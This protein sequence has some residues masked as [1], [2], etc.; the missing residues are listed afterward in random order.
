MIVGE[1]LKQRYVKLN[2]DGSAKGQSG[3][4]AAGGLIKDE[5]GNWIVGFTFKIGGRVVSSRPKGTMEGER[6]A[7]VSHDLAK[8]LFVNLP[9]DYCGVH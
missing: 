4:A 3:M 7:R 9:A 1:K 5:N 2:I 8:D 6:D